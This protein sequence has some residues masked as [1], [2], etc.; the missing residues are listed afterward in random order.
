MIQG[1]LVEEIE[2]P[3]KAVWIRSISSIATARLIVANMTLAFGEA[4]D[5]FHQTVPNWLK[6]SAHFIKINR[7]KILRKSLWGF[8][9]T[10]FLIARVSSKILSSFK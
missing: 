1:T 8:S 6:R 3:V 2:W 10:F 9:A 7:K 4:R 5:I